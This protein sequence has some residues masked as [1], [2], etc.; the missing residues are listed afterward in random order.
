M[1]N[2][3]KNAEKAE[4][5]LKL[6]SDTMILL[7]RNGICVDIAV[8]NVDMWFLKEDR[9][10]GKNILRLLPPVTYRQVYPEFK[11]VLR[12]REV[13]SRNYELAIGDTT[14]FFKCIMRPYEDM[15]LCQYRDITERS[16]RKLK[17]EKTNRELNEIQKAALIGRWQYDSGK[18]SFCYTGH[19][20]VM[21]TEEEQEILLEDYKTHILP[22]DREVFG[23]WLM[24]NL[25]G[26]MEA[27]IDYRIHFR[28][29]VF[30]I[31]LKT[32]SYEKQPDGN[33]LLEGYIQNITDIQQRRNDI[34]LLTHAI[35]NS[36]EDIFA[37]HEDGALVFA[38][39]RFRE[40]H[41]IGVADD[42]SELNIY[43]IDMN[44]P[45][46]NFWQGLLH[47][48]K[49]GEKRSGFVLYN[50]LPDHPEVLAMEGS[51]YWVTSDKGEAI[52]WGFGRDITQRIKNEQ[53]IKRFSQI[54]DK[55]IE[56]LPAGIVVKD[57]RSG[58]K[59]L[60]RNRESYNRNIPLKEA[61]G[62]D[63]FD[64]YP[65]DVAQEKRTQDIE[66]AR[67][68]VEKHWITEE[69]DQNGKS[70]FLDKRKIR[71]ES[72]DFPPIL[73]SIE[74]DITEMERMKRELLVAKEKA[75][76]SDQLK[77]AFLANMSH[78]IR[79]PLNA[80]VG[81]SDLLKDLEAFSS[82]EVQQF[83]ET[84][85]IN[86]TLLLALINDILDLSRIE[87]GTMDFQLSSYNLTFIMQQVYDSQ[88][89]SMPQG[90]ELRTDFPEGT[91]KDI[92]TDS[93]RL[94]QVV[95]NLINNA[96]KFTAKGSI[97]LGY[98]MEE[99]GY[100]TVFVEDTGA[101]ISDED[102]KHI[103]ERFYKADSF[104]QGAGLGLSICQTIVE[105][106]HGTITVT[107]KLGRG[108]RFEVRLSDD[109]M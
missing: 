70:I 22:E 24:Q 17:L 69:H 103:F 54:L 4:E 52:L 25:Q 15:V 14:Y 44:T 40:H 83:V 93:V 82:E 84:I 6:T 1:K 59:Y 46:G 102:Q 98:S 92:V 91:G 77:S 95:N 43:R 30:Y 13:S 37:A 61:L 109:V 19:S 107:S 68:G 74:W 53:Q 33:I 8:Y 41:N 28:K 99:P 89:L 18:K 90:V 64:F 20:G 97:T 38:N 85:N 104:T 65:F 12:R 45:G 105:R 42:I 50:P 23:K 35:N 101:G 86:C 39:R 36:T 49:K 5:L 108:T 66:I 71:I 55:T 2:I 29:R 67:T 73:L 80:I 7:D 88:R 63:D 16:Q 96:R 11:K 62:K 87:S 21:C 78:E 81:F 106:L 75:E 72:D 48:L 79:T 26:D 94:K 31:R 58:F 51:A 60:Y 32:F 100:T 3:L 9:L 56:N 10:L 57:I 47:S 27:S 76:T 34:N